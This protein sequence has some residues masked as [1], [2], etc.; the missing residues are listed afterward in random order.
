MTEYDYIS[1]LEK[2]SVALTALL[3]AVRAALMFSEREPS[4]L[5]KGIEEC[6]KAIQEGKNLD[7]LSIYDLFQ[8]SVAVPPKFT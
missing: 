6:T 3:G 1:K 7:P 4:A 5:V 8:N 2:E